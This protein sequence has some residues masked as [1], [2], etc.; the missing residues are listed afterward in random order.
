M[1]DEQ[2]RIRPCSMFG[3]HLREPAS[4]LTH[5]VAA[6]AALLGLGLLL[7][8]SRNDADKA[9]ALFVYGTSLVLVFS[10]SAAYHLVDRGPDLTRRLRK[11]DHAAIYLLIAGTYTPICLYFFTDFWRWGLLGIVW[12][13]ALVGVALKAFILHAPRWLTAGIYLLM[14]WISIMA[15]EEMLSSM[16]RPAFHWLVAGG[17]AFTFGAIIYVSKKPDFYP[18]TFGFHEVWHLFVIAG[19]FC[20]FVVIARY[21]AL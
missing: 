14:G 21:I 19:C 9:W 1:T 16:P 17:L 11:V 15:I 4:G 10:A 5:L 6:A 8:A 2:T 7:Y 20:H 18:R 3:Y 13:M 12:A